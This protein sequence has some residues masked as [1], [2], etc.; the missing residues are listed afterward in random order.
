MAIIGGGLSGLACGWALTRRGVRATVFDTGKRGPG[1]RASS[2][3][4][5]HETGVHVVDH[6]V[7][8]FTAVSEEVR[9][10]VEQMEAEGVVQ[11]WKGRVGALSK[12]GTFRQRDEAKEGQLWIGSDDRGVMAISDWLAKAQRIQKDVWV[13]KL[14]AAREEGSPADGWALKDQRNRLVAGEKA[15][16]YTVIAHNGKCADRLIRTSPWQTDAHAPLRCRFKPAAAPVAD[17]LELSSLWVC[18]VAVPRGAAQFDGA[19]IDGHPVLSWAGNNASKYPARAKMDAWT[20]ISTTH[21]GSKNKCSQEFIPPDVRERVF[22]EMTSAFGALLKVPTTG[23]QE[24]HMQLWGAAVPLN[25]CGQHYIHDPVSRVGVCGDWLTSPS[26]EG[27]LFSG[28]ALAEAIAQELVGDGAKATGVKPFYAVKGGHAIGSFGDVGPGLTTKQVVTGSSEKSASSSAPATATRVTPGEPCQG[29]AATTT[30]VWN[31]AFGANI[32]PWKLKTK[33][34]IEPV[35]EVPARLPGWR[36]KFNHSGGMGNI[37][38]LPDGKASDGGPDEVHGML[39]LLNAQD[40]EKLSKM[41]HEYETAEVEVHTYDGR[42]I[43]A[44]AFVTPPSFKLPASLPP[45]ERYLSL[46][47]KGAVTSKIDIRYRRW[48]DTLKSVQDR[49]PEYWDHPGESRRK[50]QHAES[51]D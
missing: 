45:P 37:E 2:R 10:I 16:S 44:R 46:I 14:A 23:W 35:E 13:S 29:P 18:I 17:V 27:A 3:V 21:Y 49:G 25:V 38:P 22:R 8:A 32:N 41:E 34:G 39:L 20:L 31:F 48:L 4:I 33:R 30:Q 15:W 28:L 42:K 9:G 11:R 43:M 5:E 7:Q 1:G 47:R 12:D 36:L 26:V 6:A 19:F 24:L 40:F 51:W 50:Q